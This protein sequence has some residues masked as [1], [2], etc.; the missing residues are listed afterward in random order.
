MTD[1]IGPLLQRFE[2]E[3]KYKR[4][5]AYTIDY[6]TKF[7]EDIDD[8]NEYFRVTLKMF[9]GKK[10]PTSAEFEKAFEIWTSIGAAEE[11]E[12]MGISKRGPD[13]I[14]MLLEKFLPDLHMMPKI[15]EKKGKIH[16]S[17]NFCPLANRKEEWGNQRMCCAFLGIIRSWLKII[18]PGWT[19]KYIS[20][21]WEIWQKHVRDRECVW[22]FEKFSPEY[23]FSSYAV[24]EQGPLDIIEQDDLEGP[25]LPPLSAKDQNDFEELM[26][27]AKGLGISNARILP[28]NK[29]IYDSGLRKK[30]ETEGCQDKSYHMCP[31]NNI[32]EDEF[33]EALNNY[34]NVLLLHLEVPKGNA[35]EES[36]RLFALEKLRRV[37][38]TIEKEAYMMKN[39]YAHTLMDCPCYMCGVG[40]CNSTGDCRNR[41]KARQPWKGMGVD[42]KKTLEKLNFDFDEE[43]NVNVFSIILLN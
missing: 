40:N 35:D 20:S 7:E 30:C 38:L 27:I 23:L 4:K 5:K 28:R 10:E 43:N 9:V 34:T 26:R 3:Q 32:P 29:L 16:V 1:E 13:G 8:I 42:L 41:A 14:K 11:L 2:P 31:P 25:Y 36:T 22:V 33:V 12:A 17:F 15:E 39:F 18:A 24:E 19:A 21:M 37:S 6:R